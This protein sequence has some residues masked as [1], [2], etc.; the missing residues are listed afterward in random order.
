MTGAIPE[1]NEEGVLPPTGADPVS[2][3]RSPYHVSPLDLVERFA[4]SAERR[5][6]LDGF[7]R[8]R[9][10]LH[11]CGL[12]AGTQWIDGSFVENIEALENRPP[13]DV[14]VVTFFHTPA[15]LTEQDIASKNPRLFIHDAVKRE[16]HVDGYPVGIKG[17]LGQLLQQSTYWYSLWSHT[18]TKRWKGYVALDLA[19]TNDDA[20]WSLMAI[21]GESAKP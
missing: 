19:P 15:G 16:Y 21:M 3:D 7:L 14:D 20:A 6:I 10:A 8:Y 12:V 9:S 17:N 18:R 13:K 5:L 1:W 4:S 11:A 2:A